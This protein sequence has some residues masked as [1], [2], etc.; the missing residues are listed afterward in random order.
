MMI[1]KNVYL[2]ASQ[3]RKVPH[4]NHTQSKN[5]V[6]LNFT[7]FE[8]SPQTLISSSQNLFSLFTSLN[9]D[10]SLV[11]PKSSLLHLWQQ[12]MERCRFQLDVEAA[13]CLYSCS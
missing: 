3:V 12:Q 2:R 13:L 6:L 1:Q 10:F 5:V 4:R 7:S 9:F 8:V 11:F